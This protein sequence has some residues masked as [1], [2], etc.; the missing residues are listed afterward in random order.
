M[1]R[2]NITQKQCEISQR[3]KLFLDVSLG[4]AILEPP[5]IIKTM[6]KIIKIKSKDSMDEKTHAEFSKIIDAVVRMAEEIRE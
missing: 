2:P 1:L 3:N 4:Y 6:M 5:F